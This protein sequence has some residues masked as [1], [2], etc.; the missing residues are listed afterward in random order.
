MTAH[1]Q[2]KVLVHHV[3]PAVCTGM[4]YRLFNLI[5]SDALVDGVFREI[6]DRDAIA[7]LHVE[8]AKILEN[9]AA[10]LGGVH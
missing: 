10:A 2:A 1:C 8:K 5:E 4:D 3:N 7:D 6:I 9:G